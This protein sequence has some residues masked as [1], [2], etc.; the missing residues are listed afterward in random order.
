VKLLLDEMY[1][2]AIATA[3]RDRGYDV[4]AVQEDGALRRSSDAELFEA[5]QQ[6]GRAVVTENVADFLPLAGRIQARGVPHHGL[7]LTTNR[8]FPCHRP[9]FVGAMTA[10]L[11][12]YL[13]APAARDEPVGLVHWL[14][15]PPQA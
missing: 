10:A 1:P 8:S 4:T 3:L 7:V 14:E 9:R 12:A 13:D 6:M 15:A 2:A 5:A 11:A